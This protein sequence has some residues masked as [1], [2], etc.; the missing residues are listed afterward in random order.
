MPD[1]TQEWK[2]FY[3]GVLNFL[4][5][6]DIDPEKQD[7]TKRGYKLI[8][9][10]FKGEDRQALQTLIDNNAISPEDRLTPVGAL[11]ALQSCIKDEECLWHYRDE[12]MSDFRQQPNEQIH[13]LN[14]R[15]TTLINT[16]KFQ[17]HQTTETIEIMLLQHTVKFHEA[18]DWIQLQ[19]Q[20]Q[21]TYKSLLQHCKTLEQCCEQYQKAQ[22]K[23]H[24]ELTTLSAATSASVHQDVIT[25]SHTQCTK[26][27]YKHSQDKCPATGKGYFHCH[28][29]GHYTALY[30]CP[31]QA[32][33]NHFRTNS[34][35]CYRNTKNH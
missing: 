27:G 23:G 20:S 6:L 24:A 32:K 3:T 26:C 7:E 11:K 30:R 18:R 13:A 14:T 5:A 31:R 4:E 33:N 29:T 34:W 10:M 22:L 35:S 15:I 17:D 21:L 25:S 9:M 8:K 16:C 2:T 28:T 19:N 12:L 1:Q